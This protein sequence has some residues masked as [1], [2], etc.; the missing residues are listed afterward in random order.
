[1]IVVKRKSLAKFFN[2]GAIFGLLRVNFKTRFL[3]Q[4]GGVFDKFKYRLFGE[5]KGG[6]CHKPW[7]QL[8][9]KGTKWLRVVVLYGL[10]KIPL[11]TIG[12][13]Y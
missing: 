10:V 9:S 4:Q 13:G 5:K 3:I 12:V 8:V 1:M 7:Y 6:V 2:F 11:S